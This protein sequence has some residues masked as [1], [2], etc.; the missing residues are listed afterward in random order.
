MIRFSPWSLALAAGLAT[1]VARAQAPAYHGSRPSTLEVKNVHVVKGDGTPPFGPTSVFV[2]DGKIAAERIERPE[3]VLDGTGCWLLP[4]FVNTH[5]HIQDQAAGIPIASRCILEMWLAC[6]ITTVRDNGGTF[7]KLLRLR[8]R[9]AAHEIAAPRLLIFRGFGPVGDVKEARERVRSFKAAGADGIKLW[10]NQSYDLD[11]LT[12]ILQEANAAGL[13]TTAHIGVGPTDALDYA[14]AGLNCI[15]HW[16]GVPDAALDGVQNFPADFSYSNEVD[17]FRW[18]GRLWREADPEALQAVL[19]ELVRLG[20]AWSPTFAI[21]EASRDVQRAQTQPWFADYA[22]PALAK[23]FTPNLE[24]HGSYF[25]GW[26]SADEAYWRENY[27]LWMDAVRRFASYGGIVTTGE[28]AGYIYVLHGFGLLRELELHLEAGFHPLDVLQHATFN[29]A[30]VLGKELEFGR[31]RPGLAA[32]LVVVHGN[33]LENLKVFYPGG[34]TRLVD[35][36]AEQTEGIRWTIKDGVVYHAPTLLAGV[37][38]M[39]RAAREGKA[40]REDG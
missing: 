36:K 8:Q 16:Y 2:R 31:V 14:H 9:S 20:V 10:S 39:I 24:H 27:R 13:P 37:Q 17:R 40:V 35:G 4:G 34:T 30:R 19:Q 3:L 29:G 1:P 38:A 7:P 5:G 15:E 25:I 32:D 22:H 26:T 23:F 21:Y 33:P 12:A 6:G 18:A 28:D 11:L